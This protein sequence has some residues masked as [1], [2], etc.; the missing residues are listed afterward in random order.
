M[1]CEL[2][3]KLSK[4]S[5]DTNETPRFTVTLPGMLP[6]ALPCKLLSGKPWLFLLHPH[7]HAAAGWPLLR[8][9]VASRSNA[10]DVKRS[11]ADCRYSQDEIVP[12]L[13]ALPD[14]RA[15]CE[16]WHDM[17]LQ[18]AQDDSGI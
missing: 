17:N 1:A 16:G 18:F 11:N 9:L 14:V 5:Y 4:S 12:W 13:G 10:M 6:A 2:N 3:R 7:Q 15:G 8:Y